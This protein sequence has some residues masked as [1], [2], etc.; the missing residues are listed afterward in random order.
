MVA[1][2]SRNCWLRVGD[3]LASGTVGAGC[4]LEL[5]NSDAGRG[6]YAWLKEGDEVT[7]SVERLGSLTNIVERAPNPKP[8]R[9]RIT[10]DRA[11]ELAGGQGL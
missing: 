1:Y 3:V 5:S 2:A 8:I 9:G 6:G 11:L 4:I 10:G 7:L